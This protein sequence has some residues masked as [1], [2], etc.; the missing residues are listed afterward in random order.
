[1]EKSRNGEGRNPTGD[2]VR[3]SEAAGC[4][5]FVSTHAH[6]GLI[7]LLQNGG[8]VSGLLLFLLCVV[9]SQRRPLGGPAP[10]F[11]GR[12][13]RSVSSSFAA[14]RPAAE[15]PART[16]LAGQLSAAVCTQ[17]TQRERVRQAQV[18]QAVAPRQAVTSLQGRQELTR[19]QSVL[20]W[21][22]LWETRFKD[23]TQGFITTLL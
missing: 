12:R 3:G 7:V 18:V 13:R 21:R 17:R 23:Y 20:V 5:F 10:S 1:M 6:C 2:E 9:L 16:G 15:L 22:V 14:G 8:H 4:S 19:G 11:L